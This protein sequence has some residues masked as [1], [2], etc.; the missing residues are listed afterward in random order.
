ML[1]P[2]PSVKTLWVYMT[3]LLP[4]HSIWRYK[5][6]ALTPEQKTHLSHQSNT[7]L[8]QGNLY[9][10]LCVFVQSQFS[11][12]WLFMMP[13]T[14]AHQTPLSMRFS[15]ILEW[16][17][18]FFSRG[19]SQPRDGTQSFKSSALAGGFFTTTS[20]TWEAPFTKVKGWR[21]LPNKH[22]VSQ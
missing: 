13:Y 7:L 5:Q 10:T 19:S 3:S 6:E 15:R 11:N 17:A 1:Y 20:A 16:V 18:V 2:R 12:V 9:H 14:I 4:F 22:W 21:C 8:I